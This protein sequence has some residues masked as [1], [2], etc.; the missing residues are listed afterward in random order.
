MQARGLPSRKEGAFPPPRSRGWRQK[1]ARD[2]IPHP[3]ALWTTHRAR[4]RPQRR[5]LRPHRCN[6]PEQS[7]ACDPMLTLSSLRAAGGRLFSIQN[8]RKVIMSNRGEMEKT[9][10][11][12][13]WAGVSRARVGGGSGKSLRAPF[14]NWVVLWAS[15]P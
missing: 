7:Q 6:A 5:A 13:C 10:P 3:T 11:P 4:I 9:T 14:S 8:S 15:M 12:R 2:M 1:H